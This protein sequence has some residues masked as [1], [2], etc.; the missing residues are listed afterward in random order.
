MGFKRFSILVVIRVALLFC[1]IAALAIA[2]SMQSYPVSSLLLG[3]VAALQTTELVRF[4][5]KTNK[6]LRR[7]LDSVKY[8]DFSQ[9]FGKTELGSG[10]EELGQAFNDILARFESNSQDQ[11]TTLRYLKALIDHVPVP[12]LSLHADDSLVLNNNAARRLF[13]NHSAVKKSDLESLA[14]GLPARLDT[15]QPGQRDT[16]VFDLEGAEKK[17]TIA[18][19][20]VS[21]GDRIEK[22]ISLQ[23]IQPELDAAQL[24]A[25]QDLV[26]VLTH[27]IMNSI[28]PISSLSS[29]T[30]NLVNSAKTELKKL[31][32]DTN[33]MALREELDDIF[34]AVSTIAH[35]SEGLTQ[36]VESYR[37]LT[38]LPDPQRQSID[39]DITL[40]QLASLM[41]TQQ[42]E[43][44]K[45]AIAVRI[46]PSSLQLNADPEMFEQ[47][48]INLLRNSLQA[49]ESL[50]TDHNGQIAVTAKTNKRGQLTIAVKDN[51][52]GISEEISDQIFVPFFTTK[53][54]GSGV[55]LALTRQI[56]TAHG[57]SVSIRTPKQGGTEILLTF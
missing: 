45:C 49:I 57:G 9:R 46:E 37:K 51:G 39:L 44:S 23:D 52:P 47:V 12:S 32:G 40:R 3:I 5:S 16:V 31:H 13:A 10:F 29:T 7:F 19:S 38:R 20:Q 11:E 54:D 15:L 8:A 35:R 36:F 18:V 33:T 6:E 43:S 34:E 21:I 53:R 2:L 28:T 25:W 4:I 26:R 56:M 50:P 55:G 17:F 24:Q 1:V 41:T 27:E 14:P 48:L 22:L 42:T 30:V